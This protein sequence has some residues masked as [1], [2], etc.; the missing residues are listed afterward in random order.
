MRTKLTKEKLKQIERVC[1]KDWDFWDLPALWRK[2]G[3]IIEIIG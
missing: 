3:L 1:G 2:R